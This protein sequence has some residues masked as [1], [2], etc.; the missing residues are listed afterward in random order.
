MEQCALQELEA[1]SFDLDPRGGYGGAFITQPAY[2]KYDTVAHDFRIGDEPT[3]IDGYAHF[4]HEGD[5]FVI[6]DPYPENWN[7]KWHSSDD[8]Y[9]DYNRGYYLHN[10]QH[11]GSP[12]AVMVLK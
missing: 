8:V 11:T 9:L 3:M 2:E 7:T 12:L 5:E 4:K 1:G 10:R 6:V